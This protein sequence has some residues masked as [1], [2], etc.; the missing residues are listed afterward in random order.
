M[1]R[2]VFVGAVALLLSVV[3]VALPSRS[4]ERRC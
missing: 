4:G 2:S 1:K 3:L